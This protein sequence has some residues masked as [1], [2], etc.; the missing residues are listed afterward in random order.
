MKPSRFPAL[1]NKEESLEKG[2]GAGQFLIF[3]VLL[4]RE[5]TRT[6]EIGTKRER[7]RER[8]R[9][10]LGFSEFQEIF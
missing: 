3:Y 5:L 6:N 1:I 7:E 10:S 9:L 8:V 2:S 4:E